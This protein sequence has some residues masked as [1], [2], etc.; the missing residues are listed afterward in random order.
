M[1]NVQL[2]SD[3]FSNAITITGDSLPQAI[4]ID[5]GQYSINGGSYTSAVGTVNSGDIV[6]V[7]HTSSGSYNSPVSSILTVG[8]VSDRFTSYTIG[9]AAHIPSRAP[10]TRNINARTLTF[11]VDGPEKPYDYYR[12]SGGKR[13][14]EKPNHNPFEDL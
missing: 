2:S 14:L 4:S 6:I 13:F 8:G 7:K 3:V 9:T 10:R 11:V 5:V 1:V 12:F